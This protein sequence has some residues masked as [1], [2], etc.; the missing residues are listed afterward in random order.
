M[1]NIDDVK[2]LAKSA[3]KLRCVEALL[4]TGESPEQ[5]Y[6]EASRWLGKNGFSSTG[7]YLAHCSELVLA[8]GLFPHTNAGNLN[9]SEMNDLKKTNVSMGLML[10]NSSH[11]T[12]R[13]R[14]ATSRCAKQGPKSKDS[15]FKKRGRIKN[16]NDHGNFGWNR[17]E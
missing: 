7:E 14:N 5:K 3:A 8:E 1:M 6:D 2:N 13:K 10:E 15:D 12:F 16:T 9:K 11:T 17:R 4:V